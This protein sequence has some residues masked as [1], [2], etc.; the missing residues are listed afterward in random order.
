MNTT[1]RLMTLASVKSIMQ[2]R[3]A[4]PADA[5]GRTFSFTVQGDGNVIDV[6]NKAGELVESVVEPGTVLQKKIFNTRANSQ[7]A[8][9]SSRT[10]SYLA[11]GRKFEAA[12]DAV[13]ADEAYNN[14]LN[15]CQITVGI[16]LPSAIAGKLANGIRFSGTVTKVT[17]ENGSLLT[18]DPTS[19]AV[20][21]PEI[22]SKTVFNIEDFE[23]P[24]SETPEEIAARL[25]AEKANAKKTLKAKAL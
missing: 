21:A 7:L 13:K 17:T 11:E 1:R 22:A 18:V 4:I 16:L 14:F 25:K 20:L 12:G 5:E 9:S 3:I 6:K 2:G 24:A 23:A 8:M 10:Q 19:I 15:A